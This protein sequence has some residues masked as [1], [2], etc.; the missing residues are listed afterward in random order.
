MSKITQ[1]CSILRNPIFWTATLLNIGCGEK[2]TTEDTGATESTDTGTVADTD[3]SPPWVPTGDGVAYFL[4]GLQDN[5]LLVLE[6]G[7]ITAPPSGDN[8]KAYILGDNVT[9]LYA[10]PVPVEGT[11]L[12]WQS[13][14]NSNLLSGGYTK[15]EIRLSSN[16][17][18]VYTGAVDPVVSSTYTNLLLSS[19]DTISGNGSLREIQHAIQTLYAHQEALMTLQGDLT[20]LY[21]G[22]EGMV[23]AAMGT[24][25]DY[26][27]DGTVNIVPN[28]M[29]LIGQ[30]LAET[31]DTSNLRNLVLR[32]LTL[33][34]AAAHE[35]S[36]RHHIKDLANYAY[37]CTQLVGTYVQDAVDATDNVAAKMIDNEVGMDLRLSESN[38]LLSYALDGYDVNE[39]G[40]IDDFTEGT[41]NCAIYYVSQM[42][43]M[44]IGVQ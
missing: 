26:D 2:S 7:T 30:S 22:A 25:D 13:E 23:N 41:I 44:E 27:M 11:T 16:N 18:V 40:S 24:T 36:P 37:D 34:S 14:L 31:Q 28:V 20:A 15:I 6:M 8:F 38:D 21:A 19:P 10:G 33:A 29:P 4:D 3:T 43:Y 35:I 9:E 32:D 39:D 1:L 17:S 5:S 42:A 12:S